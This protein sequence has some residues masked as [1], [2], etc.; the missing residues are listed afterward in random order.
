MFWVYMAMKWLA[1]TGLGIHAEEK[2]NCLSHRAARDHCN[3][4]G[5]RRPIIDL[6]GGVGG[7]LVDEG[8]ACTLA[9]RACVVLSDLDKRSRQP[10]CESNISNPSSSNVLHIVCPKYVLTKSRSSNLD[11]QT[12]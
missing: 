8:N 11:K 1:N 10:C 3:R 5:R 7:F 4:G 9:G 2:K 12:L 6:H